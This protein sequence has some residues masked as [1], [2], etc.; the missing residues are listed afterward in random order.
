MNVCIINSANNLNFDNYSLYTY[1]VASF[2]GPTQLSVVCSTEKRFFLCAWGEPGN[3]AT[4]VDNFV[5]PP[6]LP[7]LC[8]LIS[9]PSPQLLVYCL[10]WIPVNEEATY[11]CNLRLRSVIEGVEDHGL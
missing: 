5:K 6:P 8:S 9:R 2:P 7:K 11:I 1:M 4:Y 3:E 10:W